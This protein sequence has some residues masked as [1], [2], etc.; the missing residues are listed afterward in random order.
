MKKLV[1]TLIALAMALTCCTA[2]AYAAENNASAF[3][4]TE[5]D[6]YNALEDYQVN[7]SREIAASLTDSLNKIRNG[8]INDPRLTYLASTSYTL[9]PTALY[10]ATTASPSNPEYKDNLWDL[11]VGIPAVAYGTQAINFVTGLSGSAAGYLMDGLKSAEG[12]DE[13]LQ[14]VDFLNVYNATGDLGKAVVYAGTLGAYNAS[15][16]LLVS[17][18]AGVIVVACVVMVPITAIALPL[19]AV[20]DGASFLH[21]FGL[22]MDTMTTAVDEVNEGTAD[23]AVAVYG[24]EGQPTNNNG[25]EVAFVDGEQVVLAED[26]AIVE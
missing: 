5:Q 17:V 11:S 12:V 22:K 19:L 4:S 14:S 1:A 3:T 8:S 16:L 9:V 18:F 13:A 26:A 2:F 15:N 20:K 21:Y 10:Y 25:E 23:M 7:G 6:L 24:E